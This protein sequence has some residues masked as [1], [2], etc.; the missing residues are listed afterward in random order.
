[1]AFPIK[2]YYLPLTKCG[3]VLH[4]KSEYIVT[5]ELGETSSTM[6]GSSRVFALRE[7]TYLYSISFNILWF[8]VE[9]KIPTIIED[10]TEKR[11]YL[12][13]GYSIE[14]EKYLLDIQGVSPFVMYSESTGKFR[15]EVRKSIIGD[16]RK[17]RI[18][19]TTTFHT[20]TEAEIATNK[21]AKKILEETKNYTNLN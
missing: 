11:I 12:K 2:K 3:L 14:D 19:I 5:N 17:E 4:Y 18:P 16:W 9:V 13:E 8:K 7:L 6:E 15:A 20:R 21:L 10:V 1:M